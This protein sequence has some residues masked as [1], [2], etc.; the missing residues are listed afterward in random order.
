M[1][2]GRQLQQVSVQPLLQTPDELQ[3]LE[4][5]LILETENAGDA[6]NSPQAQQFA[7]QEATCMDQS[8]HGQDFEQ[9]EIYNLYT[10]ILA[11]CFTADERVSL[12][13]LAK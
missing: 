8:L 6:D 5:V 7:D 9:L 3:E 10:Q 11:S 1:K 4:R 12:R 13:R 2:K